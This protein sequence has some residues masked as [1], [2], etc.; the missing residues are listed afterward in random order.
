MIARLLPAL[1]A[2]AAAVAPPAPV[3][4]TAAVRPPASVAPPVIDGPGDRPSVG[5]DDFALVGGLEGSR[6]VVIALHGGSF[7]G[8]RSPELARRTLNEL[9]SAARKARLRLLVPVAPRAAEASA[10]RGQT[11]WTTPEGEARMLRVIAME[12][13]AGRIDRRRLH[14]AGHGMGATAALTLAARNP[15]LFVAVAAWSGTPEPLW[16]GDRNVVGLAEPVAEGLVGLSVYLWTADDDPILDVETLDV[17]VKAMRDV[18][19]Q[20]RV[21]KARRGEFEWERGEGGHG[22]GPDGPERALRWLR[23]R[24][25]KE[26]SR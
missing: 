4:P 23:A 3:A 13:D 10:R 7:R 18:R 11:P 16:D 26:A 9:S 2:A 17:F 1:L 12:M 15:R 19:G 8:A 5:D 24:K 22:Y 25:R 14:L 6:A 21:E 20:A